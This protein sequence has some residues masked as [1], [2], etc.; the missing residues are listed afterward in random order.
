LHVAACHRARRG[1]PGRRGGRFVPRAAEPAGGLGGVFNEI[2]AWAG[3]NVTVGIQQYVS[4]L[5][6]LIVYNGFRGQ[7]DFD[8]EP[9]EAYFVIVN[10][11][12]TF[13]PAHF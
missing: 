7:T 13:V 9:G 10:T 1:R 2:D 12:T 6:G 8:L 5:D 11:T 4:S 3:A